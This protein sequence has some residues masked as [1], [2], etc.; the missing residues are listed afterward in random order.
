[1]VNTRT[2]LLAQILLRIKNIMAV[3]RARQTY[4]IALQGGR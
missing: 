2:A 4:Q 1:M 3:R